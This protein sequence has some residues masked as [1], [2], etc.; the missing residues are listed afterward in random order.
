[1]THAHITGASA[2]IKLGSTVYN[3]SPLTDKD[4]AEL[5]AYVRF[6][7]IQ[8]A[9]DASKGQPP[10]MVDRL[11]NAAVG[12]ASSITFM[13]PQ[14]AAI[15]RSQDGVARILWHGLKH[16]HPELTHEQVRALM[17]DKTTIA[18]ANRVFKEL[19]VEPLA[20]VA[21]KGKALAAAQ[22]RRKKSTSRLS[23]GTRS[24]RKK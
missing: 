12:Q 18:E 7:H 5:D 10:D 8:T 3:A 14:G 24:R 21:A 20:E 23:K 17:Y 9:I 2:P 11:V 4:I 13:S 22:L 16:N 19:N 15:I 1:M 6:V